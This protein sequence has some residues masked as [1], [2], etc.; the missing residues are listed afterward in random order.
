MSSD[1]YLKRKGFEELQRSP[2]LLCSN[3]QMLSP[4][5][6]TVWPLKLRKQLLAAPFVSNHYAPSTITSFNRC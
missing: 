3:L 1:I 5:H 6:Q 4:V 2:T